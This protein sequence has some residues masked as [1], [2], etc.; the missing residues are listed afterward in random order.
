MSTHALQYMGY[1]LDRDFIAFQDAIQW[2][3]PTPPTQAEIDAAA[4]AAQAALDAEV[5][6]QTAYEADKTDLKAQFDVAATRLAQISN[7]ASPTNAQVIQAVRDLA[8]YQLKI[9]KYV[10]KL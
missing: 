3:I 8:T 7:A 9:L 4:P 6:D 1:K 5:A 10:R 2:F